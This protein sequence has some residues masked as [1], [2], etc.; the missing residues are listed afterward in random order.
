[1]AEV[2]ISP[3]IFEYDLTHLK[4]TVSYM[5]LVIGHRSLQ[6]VNQVQPGTTPFC[7]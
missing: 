3:K 5:G 7:D 2:E 1:M 6:Y 4:H